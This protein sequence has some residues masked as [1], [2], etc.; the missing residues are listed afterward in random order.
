MSNMEHMSVEEIE[1]SLGIQVEYNPSSFSSKTANEAPKQK[2]W[3]S[4]TCKKVRDDLTGQEAQE[5]NKAIDNDKIHQAVI[6]DPKA[7]EFFRSKITGSLRKLN[8]DE[9]KI[10]Y[11]TFYESLSDA[12]F[13]TV[14]GVSLLKKWE[15]YPDSEAA[16][17]RGTELW[18]DI[19]GQ[20]VRQEER[21]ESEDEVLRVRR[22]FVNRS[23][24]S[25][26]NSKNPELEIER[27]DG[28]RISMTQS[29]RSKDLYIVFRRFPIKSATLETQAKLGTIPQEDVEIYTLFSQLMCNII[30]GG[31]VRSA[32]TSFLRA[33]IGARSDHLVAAVMEK[34]FEL[35]LKELFPKRLIWEIQ[36]KDGDLHKSFPKLLRMDHDYVVVGEI[37][38][39]EGE[40]WL[41]S[42]ERG[43]RGGLSTYHLTYE[44]NVVAQVTNHILTDFP[45]RNYNAEFARAAKNIE[46]IFT[47]KR[48]HEDKRRKFLTGVTEVVWNEDTK[49]VIYNPIIKRSRVNGEYYYNFQI[50]EKLVIEMLDVDKEK[51]KRLINL[52]K[53]RAKSHPMSKCVNEEVNEAKELLGVV[54]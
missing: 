54:S 32:K 27:E 28:T 38:G 20:L 51:T 42:T 40:A 35:N 36:S 25:L 2:D 43:E 11:H 31:P 21:F 16:A 46:L 22:T 29:P 17:I 4:D 53:E 3:F 41:Q 14:W 47:F 39:P 24:D 15:Q 5:K 1:K 52:L 10:K 13:H 45:N 6:G 23:E 34:H 50:S 37:R 30:L 33:L 48:D 49:E 9:K 19:D 26:I 18:I 8:I 12:I 7:I 44:E